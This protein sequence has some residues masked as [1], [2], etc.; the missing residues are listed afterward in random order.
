[1]ADDTEIFFTDREGTVTPNV[2]LILDASGSM[3]TND[4]DGKTRLSVM[5]QATKDL[6]SSLSDVNV[7]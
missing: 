2:M 3:G 4:V 7:G 6:V 5:K 1:M